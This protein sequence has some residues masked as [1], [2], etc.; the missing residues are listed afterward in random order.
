MNEGDG[1]HLREN[2][3]VLG[4]F[5]CPP[6][7]VD[8]AYEGRTAPSEETRKSAE[9]LEKTRQFMFFH[10]RSSASTVNNIASGVRRLK[11]FEKVMGLP[12]TPVPFSGDYEEVALG[13]Y[14]VARATKVK[15]QS[16]SG[17]RSA[18][19]A[20]FDASSAGDGK[21][22]LNPL[23]SSAGGARSARA[24]RSMLGATLLG[25]SHVMGEE[26][27]PTARLTLRVVLAVQVYCIER[28]AATAAPTLKL[29]FLN[30][31]VYAVMNTMGLYRPNELSLCY[32]KGMWEHFFVGDRMRASGL[33]EPHIGTLFGKSQVVGVTRRT[34]GAITKVNRKGQKFDADGLGSDAVM[35]AQ[36]SDIINRPVGYTAWASLRDQPPA[37]LPDRERHGG[38]FVLRPPLAGERRYPLPVPGAGGSDPRTRRE[39]LAGDWLFRLSPAFLLARLFQLRGVDPYQLVWP[40]TVSINARLFESSDGSPIYSSRGHHPFLPR[41]RAVLLVLKTEGLAN[42]TRGLYDLRDVQVK[43]VGNYWL[44]ITGVSSMQAAGVPEEMRSGAGRWRLLAQRPGSMALY[45][46]QTTLKQKLAVSNFGTRWIFDDNIEFS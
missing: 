10:A 42:D 9:L 43:K 39:F 6:C 11:R 24:A 1:L 14:F 22:L 17:D 33:F 25:L 29:Y 45:Y 19:A 31:A 12:V 37:W 7:V 15:V 26:V 4:C 41:L 2:D 16:L 27:V 5:M 32:L 21:G 44:K 34:V 46:V 30:I 28:A 20:I 35:C 18:V 13:W 38:P 40:G 23:L 36:T 8:Y 3:D